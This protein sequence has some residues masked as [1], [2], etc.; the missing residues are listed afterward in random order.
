M[1][2]TNTQRVELGTEDPAMC[3]ICTDD[4][5]CNVNYVRTECGHQFHASCLIKFLSSNTSKF[6]CPIC[7]TDFDVVSNY[8]SDDNTSSYDTSEEYDSDSD[9]ESIESDDISLENKLS[10]DEYHAKCIEAGIT[11]KM[12]VCIVTDVYFELGR[13]VNTD[14]ISV[15]IIST[16][17]HMFTAAGLDINKY[18]YLLNA[19]VQTGDGAVQTD[20]G[21][22]NC[23]HSC[24]ITPTLDTDASDSNSDVVTNTSDDG[25]SS[26]ND[27]TDTKH[28]DKCGCESPT[29]PAACSTPDEDC[30]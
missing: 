22:S 13:G 27:S 29:I 7:R 10:I 15:D 23:T 19:Q 28:D 30:V 16:M 5:N 20:S 9:D 11:Y 14:D 24:S 3:S 4:I 21:G 17:R 25:C 18:R 12:L 6:N 2:E 8:E 1:G 26:N